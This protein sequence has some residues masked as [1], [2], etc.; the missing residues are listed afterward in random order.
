MV[1]LLTFPI[2]TFPITTFL[3]T[4]FPVTTFRITTFLITTFLIK[5]FLITTFPVTK[6][7][8]TT[9]PIT[10]FPVTK[11][12]YDF[13]SYD[14]SNYIISRITSH[15]NILF[16][17]YFRINFNFVLVYYTDDGSL[18][19]GFETSGLVAYHHAYLNSSGNFVIGKVNNAAMSLIIV[20]F[21]LRLRFPQR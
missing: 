15:V 10:K 3:I 2:T 9:F 11:F 17:I 1:E 19:L 8:R 7:P 4:T 16:T 20:V 21:I 18:E 12:H 13:S 5:T 14:I 6:F